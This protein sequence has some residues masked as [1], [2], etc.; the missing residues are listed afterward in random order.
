MQG[1]FLLRDICRLRT[2]VLEVWA[3][4]QEAVPSGDFRKA[5]FQATPDLL[6][7]K[8]WRW[9]PAIWGMGLQSPGDSGAHLSLRTIALEHYTIIWS[10][11]VPLTWK[12]CKFI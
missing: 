10:L 11:T 7:Q 6:T 12:A 5:N 2:V 1:Q 3:L 8:F 4:D 9:G